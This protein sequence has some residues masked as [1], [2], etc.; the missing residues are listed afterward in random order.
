MPSKPEPASEGIAYLSDGR[1]FLKEA[2]A[3]SREILCDYA[4]QLKERMAQLHQ[5]YDW[6]HQPSE[7]ATGA[8]VW[9]GN[10]FH[11]GHIGTSIAAIAPAGSDGALLY[12][13]NTDDV[14]GIFLRPLHQNAEERRLVH[15]SES[16]IH[17]LSAPDDDG[18][19]ACSISGLGG[20]QNLSVYRIGSPGFTEITE[21]DSLDAAAAW[22][23]GKEGQ[24]VYQTAGIGRDANGQWVDTGPAS[25]DRLDTT[26]GEIHPLLHDREHD[27]LSPQ[28]SEDGTRL[29]CIRR[30][31]HQAGGLDRWLLNLLLTP[32]RA[33]GAFARPRRSTPPGESPDARQARLQGKPFDAE[34]LR[35][36]AQRRGESH[37]DLVPK[38]WQL[39]E[40]PL[41][42]PSTSRASVL[43]KGVIAYA[44]G[45]DG[46]C[47]Y[48][49]GSAIFQV[50]PDGGKP[51]LIEEAP[52]VRQ[53]IVL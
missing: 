19:V 31:Y 30:P 40:T 24:L 5:K 29:Y 25:I 45:T 34:Q 48:S 41:K 46:Q 23:P 43:A 44:L 2:G 51:R 21:G 26:R 13:L 10:A 12:G 49:N 9:G 32:L 27:Y 52:N 47:Y 20:L 36:E 14:A 6:T 35:E 15:T 22:I 8:L 11:E 53:L 4:E 3:Q 7:P 38:T 42:D 33:I 1:L 37:P 17:T 16:N 28:L 18:Q 50:A 39:I